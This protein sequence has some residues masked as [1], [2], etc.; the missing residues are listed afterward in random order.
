MNMVIL[1]KMDMITGYG[2]NGYCVRYSFKKSMRV[3]QGYT[4]VAGLFDICNTQ[5]IE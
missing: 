4:I 1:G 5:K 3:I 2:G